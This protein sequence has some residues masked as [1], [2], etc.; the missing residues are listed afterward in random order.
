MSQTAFSKVT[1]NI[2]YP[3]PHFDFPD[4]SSPQG[5]PYEYFPLVARKLS[6][7]GFHKESLELKA[8]NKSPYG[9][10][11]NIISRYL[12]LS[13]K[14]TISSEDED[15]VYIKVKKDSPQLSQV[16]WF[17]I[18]DEQTLQEMIEQGHD[19]SKKNIYGRTFFHYIKDPDILSYML[20]EN[21]KHRWLFLLDTDNFDNFLLHCQ[22]SIKN[23]SIV[24]EATKKEFPEFGNRFLYNLNCYGKTSHEKLIDLL[25]QNL[26][27][28]Y[29]D[30]ASDLGEVLKIFKDEPEQKEQLLGYMPK[31]AKHYN[32]SNSQTSEFFERVLSQSFCDD[33]PIQA[34]RKI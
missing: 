10:H 7:L 18:S 1:I 25:N 15:Y 14:E 3:R 29:L 11:F 17:N 8:L 12:D 31:L 30:F 13:P 9:E 20:E 4:L 21:K 23:F 16:S 33:A 27:K 2:D 34:K 28:K 22:T 6:S 32:L 19:F 24:F 5:N 26:H